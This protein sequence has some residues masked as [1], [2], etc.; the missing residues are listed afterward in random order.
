MADETVQLDLA[1]GSLEFTPRQQHHFDAHFS[2]FFNERF[3][4]VM[5]Q[6]AGRDYRV[7]IVMLRFCDYGNN[8]HVSRS[9][10]ARRTGIAMNHISS[11]VRKLERLEIITVIERGAS[12][13]LNERYF[14]RGT[15]ENHNQRRR[16][17]RSQ[18]AAVDERGEHSPE[19][20]EEEE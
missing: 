12:Y 20:V 6:L 7:L 8:V 18:L 5:N 10:L 9:E 4:E 14:W 1:E 11:I 16:E 17:T 13:Q 19:Q 3:E 15:A 2:V